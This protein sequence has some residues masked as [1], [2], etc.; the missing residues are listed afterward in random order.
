MRISVRTSHGGRPERAQA[1]E[2]WCIA[3]RRAGKSRLAS[4]IA[5]YLA[6]FRDY[7]AVLSVGDVGTLPV[8]AADRRQA[9]T[10]MQ[11]I[12]GLLDETPM[13]AALVL[14]RTAD[15][16]EL[17]TGVR[18]DIHTAS[19]RALRGYTVVGCVLDEVCFWRSEDSSNPDHGVAVA[20]R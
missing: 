13:L 9:R 7:T 6:A 19:W 5:V 16:V 15:S 3:G 10:C 20:V 18:I 17:S 2:A 11:Y 4:V 14:G 8:V 1:R 12:S